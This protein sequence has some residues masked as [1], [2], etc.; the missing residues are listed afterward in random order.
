MRRSEN[1]R[2]VLFHFWH[3]LVLL[4]L[5]WIIVW[6]PIILMQKQYHHYGLEGILLFVRDFFF[7]NTFDA[8][9]F[10]GAL[11]VGVPIVYGLSKVLKE[12]MVWI[13][14]FAVYLYLQYYKLLPEAWQEPYNWYNSFKDPG[15]AFPGGLL[16]IAIGFHLSNVRIVSWISSIKNIYFWI[17][18]VVCLVIMTFGNIPIMP[19]ILCVILLFMAAYTWNLPTNNQ[20][21]YKRLRAYSIMFY[22]IHDS[23]K[24]IPKQLFGWQNG[25]LLYVVT[26]AFCF[27]A[28]E[29]I[30]RMKNVRGFHWLKYAY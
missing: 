3:R 21:V 29:F 11:I 10:L 30:L 9:W 6:S 16:W 23:F 22:V 13:I 1:Q 12:W 4:Y 17:G 28:S 8:S 2:Q 20:A 7:G 25:P 26:L 14:P 15:L 18:F 19:S 5:F 27:L 24:K